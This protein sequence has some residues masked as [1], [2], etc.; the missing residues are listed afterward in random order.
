MI[1]LSSKCYYRYYD[2]PCR[3][4]ETEK[5]FF[6]TIK[7]KSNCIAVIL[8]VLH[9]SYFGFLVKIKKYLQ[10]R[11]LIFCCKELL[12]KSVSNLVSL[13]AAL[14]IKLWWLTTIFFVLRYHLCGM[15][16]L[17]VWIASQLRILAEYGCL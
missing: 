5:F 1:L 11:S 7:I 17:G 16:L 2:G 10:D 12:I 13:F 4:L 14:N 9:L 3:L 6:T 8:H 15:Q